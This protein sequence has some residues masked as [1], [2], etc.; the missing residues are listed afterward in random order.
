[1]TP[2]I[3]KEEPAGG[4]RRARYSDH[5][6]GLTGFENTPPAALSQDLPAKPCWPQ[7][8]PLLRQSIA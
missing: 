1:M 6:W 2:R 7:I 3:T 8:A 4:D 5:A